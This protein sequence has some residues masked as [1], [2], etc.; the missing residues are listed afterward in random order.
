MSAINTIYGKVQPQAIP[1]EEAVLGALMLDRDA[2][3]AV[4]DLLSP[5]S[6]YLE[7]HQNIY[8][9]ILSLFNQSN[10]VDLLTVT[11]ELRKNGTLE[12]CGGPYYLV[13]LSNRVA[14]A[15]N[16]EY[17]ARIIQQKWMQRKLIEAGSLILQEAYQ[18]T[19]DIFEM[20]GDAE[21]A[22]FDITSGASKKDA[23]GAR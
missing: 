14:S 9:A 13:E 18:D 11:E 22:I 15:A 2:V 4:I 12:K 3:M 17:H 20:I 1:L 6:F 23:K 19:T 21:K 10:P 7:A 5:E 8:R 16:I